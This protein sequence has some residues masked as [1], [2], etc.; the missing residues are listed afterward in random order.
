MRNV[1]YLSLLVVLAVSCVSKAQTPETLYSWND[2]TTQ[3][4]QIWGINVPGTGTGKATASAATGDLVVTETGTGLPGGGAIGGS[5]WIFDDFDRPREN[6]SGVKGNTDL[7]G[8]Q[9]VE[10]DVRH[11]SATA[12][13]AAQ[14]ILAPYINNVAAPVVLPVSIAPGLNTIQFPLSNLTTRQQGSIK[15]IWLATSDHSSA[16]NLTWT[17]SAVRSVGT[18]LAYRDVVTSD[19]GTPDAGLDGAYPLSTGD[20]LAIA[21]NDGNRNQVGLSR[22]PAGSGSLQWTDKGG[23]G[24]IGS[25]SGASIGW[26]N[27]GG[28]RSGSPGD[29]TSGNS[30]WERTSDFS[31]YDRMTV[32]ISAL[33]TINPAGT[34]G[35][36]GSF[37]QSDVDEIKATLASQNLT[38]DGQYH[39]LIYDLSS[40][41][42]LKTVQNWGI[43]VAPHLN[44]IVFNVDNIR[45]WNS[46]TPQGVQGDYNGNGVVDAGDYVKWRKGGAL[47][48]E[49]V[50][51]GSNTPE[52]Y[53]FWRSRFGAI[54]GSGTLAA[55][56]IPE[57]AGATLLLFAIAMCWNSRGANRRIGL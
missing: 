27:G 9:Y 8:L 36:E 46:T 52:D 50:T 40:V 32:R 1:A 11:N 39:E 28:W 47:Q 51:P 49:G 37:I 20:M 54:T 45:L 14:F 17:I 5:L 44:N 22:N 30:Y 48:N 29:P 12:T 53:T 6:W 35:I 21:G 16:G 42:F 56:T 43:D 4:W 3:N 31:N 25:E 38:T 57:P 23:T 13:V 7:T 18:P 55:G 34:V 41:S 24:D 15:N 26:G 33:D 10:M 2:L 19:A